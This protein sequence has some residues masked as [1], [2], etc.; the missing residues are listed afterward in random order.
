MA[1]ERNS[2]VI[3]QSTTERALMMRSAELNVVSVVSLLKPSS[4]RKVACSVVKGFAT[5]AMQCVP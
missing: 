4:C 3:V 2:L 1:R 5:I